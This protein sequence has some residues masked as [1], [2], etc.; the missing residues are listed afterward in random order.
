MCS[1]AEQTENPN[2]VINALKIY[3]KSFKHKG[4]DKYMLGESCEDITSIDSDSDKSRDSAS[5][6]STPTSPGD[7][8]QKPPSIPA[9]TKK[10]TI[11]PVLNKILKRQIRLKL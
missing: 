3:E 9:K 4:N 10:V 11:I 6:D 5:S 7:G 8:T 1:Q 2:A